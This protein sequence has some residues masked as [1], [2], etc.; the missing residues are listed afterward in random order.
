MMTGIQQQ[1]GLMTVLAGRWEQA[2]RKVAGLAEAIPASEF[3]ART[4]AA[5]RSFSEG[6]HHV[7][8]WNQYVAD[9]LNGKGGADV[10]NE[11]PVAPYPTKV[12]ILEPLK[13]TSADLAVALRE[14]NGP[15]DLKATELIMTF[16]EHA[17][18]HYCQLVVYPRLMGI[19]PPTSRT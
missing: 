12:S 18:E 17:S 8:F 6:F 2:S 5:T 14:H 4:P 11:L 10:G 1:I 7:G 9:T 19:V 13:R 16:V 15:L 3:D